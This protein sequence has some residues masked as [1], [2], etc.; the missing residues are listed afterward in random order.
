MKCMIK[1]KIDMKNKNQKVGFNQVYVIGD[2]QTLQRSAE[3]GI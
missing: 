3:Y 1:T 2:P